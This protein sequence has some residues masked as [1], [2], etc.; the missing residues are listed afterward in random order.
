MVKM[1]E[2]QGVQH[3]FG[4]CGD[5]TLPFYDAMYKLDH[6]MTHVLTRDE[7]CATYMADAYSRVTG[8]PGVC[9]GPSGGGATYI[10]PGL[11]EASE[12]SYAVLGITTDI[13]VGSYGK[14]PLT[15]VDQEAL[16]RPLTKWNTV[17]KCADHIPRMVRK[18]FRAMTTG[19]SGAAHL[20]LPYDIQ[21]DAVDPSDIW[22]DQQ[23]TS[24]PAYRQAPAP[25]A[26]EAAVDAILSAKKPLIVCGGGVVIAGAM[27]ELDRLA[28]R[29]DIPV[30]TSISGQGS[31]AETHPN[32]VGVVGSNGGTDETWEAMADA[33]LVVFMGARAGSTTTSRWE[34]PSAKTRV[35][36]FDNDPMVIGANYE[37][38]VGVVGDL[39][40]S[41]EQV[42]AVLD[43]RDQ[44]ADTFGGAAA[45][46]D[47]KK[48]KFE[49]FNKLAQSGEA[50]IRPE[51]VIDAMMKVLPVD[52]TVI[53]D[54]GTSCPYFSAYYQLPQSGR[55]FITNRAHGALGYSLSAALG[56]WYGRPSSK[57]VAM[58]GDGSFGF[59]CGE[60]ETVC[61]SRAPITYIVFSNSNYGWIKA[62]QYADTDA[63]YYNV[64]F[65]RTDQ[66]AVAAAYGVKSWRV[67]NPDDLERVLKE[68][69]EHDGPTLIDVVTQPLEEANAPVRRW[70]G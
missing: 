65:N 43:R 62:S 2:A 48:R 1:L 30:A 13:S 12:S 66:A 28:T 24:Y 8:R 64:D 55:H 6:K 25:G 29:L 37:V 10:L 47:I 67:E 36:H 38:E 59:T 19:R 18:A 14:Y 7:R 4:L 69:I 33:D 56:A 63:R 35:V 34:A 70:M 60:L 58:M 39:K 50:P 32:C 31:L 21:Y 49:I 61:R 3:I 20:G 44:G 53:S 15:E 22:A 17:I 68:A 57:V 26:A 52:A 9:E 46:A 23:L 27:E 41:L 45:V 40:L 5:T 51:R 42:N 11:I 54:P 16:M